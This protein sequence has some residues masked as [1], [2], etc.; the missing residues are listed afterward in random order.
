[1][2]I[3]DKVQQLRTQRGWTQKELAARVGTSEGYIRHIEKNRRAPNLEL[4]GKLAEALGVEFIVLYDPGPRDADPFRELM[5]QARTEAGLPTGLL[6]GTA[7]M[8]A[9]LAATI[10]RFGRYLTP[11]DWER[12]A[13]Y[14]EG[15]AAE[16][17][18]L[19][20]AFGHQ[21]PE[22]SEEASEAPGKQTA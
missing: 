8:P 18:D 10:Q 5:A 6:P 7:D 19:G 21:V 1:M 4:A 2:M 11:R 16:R 9:F 12:V 13:A 3:G 22:A 17:A 20:A 14:L 15:L